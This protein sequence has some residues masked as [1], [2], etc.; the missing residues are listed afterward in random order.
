M[1]LLPL[2]CVVPSMARLAA[3]R[4]SVFATGNHCQWHA[5]VLT[6]LIASLSFFLT[7]CNKEEGNY[8]KVES[9]RTA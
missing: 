1:Q 5:R 8:A 4:Y 3:V 7:P 6:V 2:E 9:W